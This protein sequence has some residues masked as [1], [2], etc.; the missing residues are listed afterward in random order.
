MIRERYNEPNEHISML[1]VVNVNDALTV[2][3]GT[4]SA[5]WTTI[6]HHA[7]TELNGAYSICYVL[8]G[9][10]KSK[11]HGQSETYF[12]LA[13]CIRH[14]SDVST[15]LHIDFPELGEGLGD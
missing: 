8:A 3:F 7:P 15:N 2:D 4:F 6:D 11:D 14:A 9:S 1:D 13:E 10:V 12:V 5:A